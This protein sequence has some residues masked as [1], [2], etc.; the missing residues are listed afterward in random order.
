METE[1]LDFTMNFEPNQQSEADKKLMVVFFR[2]TVKNEAKSIAE[3]RPIFDEI[4]LVKVLTPGSRDTFVGDATPDYQ[5]RF[6]S[7]WARYQNGLE[8]RGA[9]GTPLN[10]LAWLGVGQIAEFNALNIYTVEQLAGM[11]DSISQKFMGHLQI[12]QR[13][14]T[15]LDAA[16]SAAPMMKLEAELQSRDDTI[17]QQGELMAAMK[18]RLDAIEAEQNAGKVPMTPPKG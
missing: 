2:G 3:G 8:Q 12:K 13:A 11:A 14:Q 7:Q 10:Q 15:Y 9:G 5:S 4:D 6:P 1:A 16:S 18:S 17:R